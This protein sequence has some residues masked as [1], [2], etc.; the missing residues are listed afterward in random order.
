MRRVRPYVNLSRRQAQSI[1]DALGDDDD[2]VQFVREQLAQADDFYRQ[3]ELV[4]ARS[5]W[6]SLVS[7]YES[8][9]E[10]TFLVEQAKAR[11][12]DPE[13]AIPPPE[14]RETDVQKVRPSV[15]TGRRRDSPTL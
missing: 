13:A 15:G 10:F 2:P 8:N 11:L 1:R 6:Q 4:R 12:V 14:P 5:R 3:G 9:P 7:L